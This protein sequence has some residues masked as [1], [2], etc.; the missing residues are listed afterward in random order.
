M[1]RSY[2]QEVAGMGVLGASVRLG[3]LGLTA[4]LAACGG[5]SAPKVEVSTAPAVQLN[6]SVQPSSGVVEVRFDAVQG[7]QPPRA[8]VR[9]ETTLVWRNNDD[10]P[11]TLFVAQLEGGPAPLMLPARGSARITLAPASGTA[12]VAAMIGVSADTGASGRVVV[13]N[14]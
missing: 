6:G 14:N 13:V 10:A 9:P 4:T 2:A 8:M 7:F 5:G 3:I 12:P 11:H 1:D